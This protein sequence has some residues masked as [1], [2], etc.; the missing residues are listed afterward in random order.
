MCF[1]AAET[2]TMYRIA[3]SRFKGLV[4]GAAKAEVFLRDDNSLRNALGVLS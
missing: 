3:V 2:E 4:M 1:V